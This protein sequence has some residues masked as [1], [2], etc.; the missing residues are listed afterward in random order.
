MTIPDLEVIPAGAAILSRSGTALA[1]NRTLMTWLGLSPG[2]S[3]GRSGLDFLHPDDLPWVFDSFAELTMGHKRKLECMLR[4]MGAHG[5]ELWG[6]VS[7][8]LLGQIVPP[9]KVLLL[10]I[11][12]VRPELEMLVE[13]AEDRGYLTAPLDVFEL[14]SPAS[15]CAER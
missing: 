11:Q 10:I 2:E 3:F 6:I 8:H 15:S 13:L 12:D 7:A 4:L 5:R 9:R 14:M 1:A